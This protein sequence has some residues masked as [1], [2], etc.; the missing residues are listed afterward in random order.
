MVK[1]S[2]SLNIAAV[3]LRHPVGYYQQNGRNVGLVLQFP[4]GYTASL[5]YSEIG[6]LQKD[7]D[8]LNR[9]ETAVQEA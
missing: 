5:T 8:G 4:D 1:M 9:P 6:E 7:D 2:K 3:H